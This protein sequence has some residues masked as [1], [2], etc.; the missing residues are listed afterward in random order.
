MPRPPAT[1][2]P[3]THLRTSPNLL[4]SPSSNRTHTP[5]QPRQPRSAP[6]SH[7]QTPASFPRPVRRA[8]KFLHPASLAPAVPC[9]PSP[10]TCCLVLLG[11]PAIPAILS[12]LCRFK[13][14]SRQPG[15]SLLS[16]ERRRLL[17]MPR[18]PTGLP[19]THARSIIS[20]HAAFCTELPHIVVKHSLALFFQWCSTHDS[21][22]AAAPI[23]TEVSIRQRLLC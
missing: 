11:I 19:T 9:L 20:R 8:T 1:T 15:R 4:L 5:S 12:T 22:K 16:L 18:H 21:H 7:N 17:I 2:Q 6:L 23:V 10:I 3:T 13:H 14:P